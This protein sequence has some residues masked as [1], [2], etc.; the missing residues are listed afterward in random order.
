MLEQTVQI[1]TSDGLSHFCMCDGEKEMQ[2][3]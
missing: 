3:R 2:S 1:I